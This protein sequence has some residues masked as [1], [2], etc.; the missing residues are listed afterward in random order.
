MSV[1]N[2][3][4]ASGDLLGYYDFQSG[5]VLDFSGNDY[6][7]SFLSAP[8]FSKEGLNFDGV[9]DVVL[10][11]SVSPIIRTT[12]YS[13]SF[14]VKNRD[15]RNERRFFSEGR[16]TDNKPLITLSTGTAGNEDKVRLYI[17]D[18]SN[19]VLIGANT[20]TVLPFEEWANITMTDNN[21]TVKMYINGVE[22]ATSFDYTPAT[23][24]IDITSIGAVRRASTDFAGNSTIKGLVAFDVVLTE[25]EVNQVMGETR[26]K[27]WPTK[28]LNKNNEKKLQD[29]STLTSHWIMKPQGATIVDETG[30]GN[31]AS[32]IGSPTFVETL[33]GQGALMVD[34]LNRFDTGS[35]WVGT[36]ALTFGCWVILDGYGP[37]NAGR[38][39]ENGKTLL[40]WDGGNARMVFSSDGSTSVNSATSSIILGKPNFVCVT[41]NASGV[42]NFYVD[43]VLSG[44]AD[45]DSGTP[46]GGTNN[47]IFGNR[48]AGDR[49]TEGVIIEPF[50][51]VGTVETAAQ[52]LAR[53]QKGANVVQFKTDW[54]SYADEQSLGSGFVGSTPWEVKTGSWETD[55]DTI[56]GQECKVFKCN[57]SGVLALKINNYLDTTEGSFGTWDFWLYKGTDAGTSTVTIIDEDTTVNNVGGYGIRLMSD[58]RIQFIEWGSA[59]KF[60]TVASYVAIQTWYNIK[61]TR[62]SLGVFSA[63]IRGGAFGWDWVLIDVTGGTGTNPFTDITRTT[64]NYFVIDLDGNDKMAISD[65]TG[66]HSFIK[67][68]GQV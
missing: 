29:S 18:D 50:A 5:S 60:N 37:S 25:T 58:E 22:D 2:E 23:M 46:T 1:I 38:L 12:G 62:D 35:D 41:R 21:G 51:I 20:T 16:S 53:Y 39:F 45:Q 63:Y 55:T 68:V 44:S 13:V 64:N 42:T 24:T 48:N 61:I 57:T 54:G 32:V 14:W 9:S 52:I 56:E 27:I 65:K 49:A 8:K 30:A 4:R 34:N 67:K 59:E 28:P 6:H 10:V 19:T 3:K 31:D 15:L 66:G 7:G 26:N 11:S 17:R 33:L 43:G 36:G 47:V 40:R